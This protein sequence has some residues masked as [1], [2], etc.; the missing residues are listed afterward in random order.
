MPKGH[1]KYMGK[2]TT[3]SCVFY[4]QYICSVVSELSQ[5]LVSSEGLISYKCLV[6]GFVKVPF[7]KRALAIEHNSYR[8]CLVKS[9][10]PYLRYLKEC[11]Y[12]SS[13]T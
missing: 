12:Y 7:K 3:K 5:G 13:M 2:N 9:W 8:A 6:D 11:T 10:R 1:W 4:K